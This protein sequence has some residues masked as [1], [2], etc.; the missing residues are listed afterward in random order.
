MIDFVSGLNAS[1]V[2]EY[3]KDVCKVECKINEID[4]SIAQRIWEITV[5]SYRSIL[6]DYQHTDGLKMIQ[7]GLLII[8]D[9]FGSRL[10]LIEYA[11]MVEDS[12]TED[13]CEMDT[14][15]EMSD[16]GNVMMTYL[17]VLIFCILF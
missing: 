11:E 1:E 8:Y 16:S 13:F 2:E 4:S 6:E 12:S 5:T 7:K 10:L 17:I 14:T 9:L 15:L 3:K